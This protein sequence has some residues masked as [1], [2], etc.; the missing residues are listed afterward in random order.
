M[1]AAGNSFDILDGASTSGTF[2]S[3]QLPPLSAGLQ[4]DSTQLYTAGVLSVII[5]GDYNHSGNVDVADYVVWRKGLGATYTRSD[6]TPWRAN[7]GA[8]VGS[9]TGTSASAAVP[10]PGTLL[11]FVTGI[12]A[13]Y[14]RR[15]PRVTQIEKSIRVQKP[16]RFQPLVNKR[17]F[18]RSI[19]ALFP[20]NLSRPGRTDI[21][22]ER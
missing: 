2:N 20:R 13:M 19:C 14:S 18:G 10:E 3:I 16:F 4:W 11:L 1:P 17:N 15:Q 12:V 21:G 8:A 7:F 5:T 9:G 22:C 6:Y